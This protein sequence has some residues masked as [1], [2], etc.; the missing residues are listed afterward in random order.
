MSSEQ[1]EFN[2][3][4]C[5]QVITCFCIL[6]VY[7]MTSSLFMQLAERLWSFIH[8]ANHNSFLHSCFPFKDG[9]WT[10]AL[11]WAV[12]VNHWEVSCTAVCSN[13]LLGGESRSRNC[14]GCPLASDGKSKPHFHHTLQSTAQLK[15]WL[16]FAIHTTKQQ[17]SS[18]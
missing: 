13:L 12:A 4:L 2:L 8:Y 1:M 15:I 6:L 3:F 16:S 10:K 17:L 11:F 18:S 9:F 14:T 5:S 7:L